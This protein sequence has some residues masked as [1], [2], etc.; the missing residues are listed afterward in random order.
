MNNYLTGIDCLGLDRVLRRGTAEVLARRDGAMLLKDC[1][2]EAY[3]LGCEDAAQGA[4]LLECFLPV[5]CRLLMVSDH[6]LGKAAFARFGFQEL[7]ECRQTAY[8]GEAPTVGSELCV[9]TADARDLPLLTETYHLV[10]PEELR[11][12]VERKKLLLGYAQGV[13]VGFIGEH[14]EGS[15][16]LLYVFPEFRRRGCASALERLLIAKTLAEGYVPFGQVEKS[17]LASLALQ[18]KLGMTISENLICWMWK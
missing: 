8:Y 17:N 14:L 1:V 15:M 5:D 18:E 13:L 11:R 16:G 12:I 2:S 6:A 4:E 9:R 3:F 10:E 7:L